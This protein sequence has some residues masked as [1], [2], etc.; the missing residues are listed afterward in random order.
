[1]RRVLP[2]SSA[3]GANGRGETGGEMSSSTNTDLTFTCPAPLPARDKVLLGH[4]SG[5]K[6][7]AELVERIFLPA[8][9]NPA[10]DLLNDQ[11]VVSINGQRIAMTTDSFVVNP[12]F[13]PGGDIGSLAV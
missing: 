1:M 13:F 2:I 4:G 3:P 5:G 10:L 7:S 11:A 9:S 6:L 12:L 8:F